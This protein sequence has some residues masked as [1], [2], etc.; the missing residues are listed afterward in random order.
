MWRIT[1]LSG[2]L[3]A[4]LRIVIAD[5]INAMLV[6]SYPGETAL[7]FVITFLLGA[8]VCLSV[9]SA[10]FSVH[11]RALNVTEKCVC[12]CVSHFGFSWLIKPNE[13]RA[14]YYKHYIYLIWISFI[15]YTFLNVFYTY[16]TC[17]TNILVLQ[18]LSYILLEVNYG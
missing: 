13:N 6:I 16:Y 3:S 17:I 15:K 8:F 11:P 2:I 4:S 5:K 9:G 14:G 12:F 7:T 18:I 1:Y 10:N